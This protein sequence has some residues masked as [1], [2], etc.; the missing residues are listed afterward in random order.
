[1]AVREEDT[2]EFMRLLY[3]AMT[4]AREKLIMVGRTPGKAEKSI[5]D[6][7]TM[8]NRLYGDFAAANTFKTYD[9][10]DVDACSNFFDMVMPVALHSDEAIGDDAFVIR[11][12]EQ[13]ECDFEENPYSSVENAAK[14]SAVPPYPYE[15]TGA[16]KSKVTV[17]ELK[18]QLHDADFE[19]DE[20]LDEDVRRAAR[21]A[22]A[23]EEPDI[24]PK[25]YK[26]ADEPLKGNLR[27]TAYHRIMEILD[28]KCFDGIDKAAV[29]EKVTVQLEQMLKSAKI[30][31]QQ[32]DCIDARD[33]AAFIASN[34]GQRV[35]RA[36]KAGEVHREQPFV[37]ID[38]S[39][40]NQLIQGVIDMYF[41]E[42]GELV[43]VDY[44]T[45][46]VAHGKGE[47][48]LKKRY[49]IQLS[50]YAKALSQIT[51]IHVKELLIYSFELKKCIKAEQQNFPSALEVVK[52][53]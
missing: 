36:D 34:A 33:I 7:N 23:E 53:V 28:F 11:L 44:K 48:I 42:D 9:Y 50:Y 2:S 26:D 15:L 51:G 24:V 47:E 14:E 41:V 30:T 1:M 21:E 8:K 17:T 10:A 16:V 13:I 45:D 29:P 40:E 43:I 25:F 37:Y 35:I 20:M 3:V 49:G 22:Q 12:H 19:A 32:H 38:D 5:S 31:Q 46:R 39:I 52:E 6:W 27:G 4:R 18:Q